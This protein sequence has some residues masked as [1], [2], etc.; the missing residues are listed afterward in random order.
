MT[1]RPLL[2]LALLLAGASA[3]HAAA[4]PAWNRADMDTTCAP[5]RNFYRYADGGWLD[6]SH[7]PAG[8]GSFGSFEE[9]ELRN[10]AALRALLEKASTSRS[11]K[12]STN[13]RLGD[14]YGAC[15]DSVAAEQAGLA[16]VRPHLDGI[17]SVRTP[18]TLAAE[19]GWLHANGIG[20]AFQLA[21]L[22]DPRR[23]TLTIAILGQGGLGL[24]DRDYYFREDTASLSLRAAYRRHVEKVFAMIGRPN[25]GDEARRVLALETRLAR[26]SMTNVE[27]RDPQ[28]TYHKV[29]LDTLRAWAPAV[30]WEAYFARRGMHVPDSLDVQQPGF[31]RALA[32]RFDDTPVA[33]WQAYLRWHVMQA[34]SPMLSK[35]YS[36]EAFAFD[37]RLT[38]AKE[39]LPRWERCVQ[40]ADTDL[41]DLLGA[42][43]VKEHFS[44][45]ARERA[46][47]MVK[48]M[49]AALG[50]RI[51]AVTWMSDT[52][53][54]AAK[55]KLDA[56]SEK[57]GYPDHARDYAGV[58]I[59]RGS[60]WSNHEASVRWDGER[61]IRKIGGPVDKHEWAMTAPT[62]NA[63][64][65]GSFNSINFPAGILQ[66]PFYDPSWDDALNYGAIG[67]VIG[68]EMTHGFDDR[69]RQFDADG[70]LRDW[71]TAAD[72]IRYKE[73]AGR[74]AAQFDGYAAIDTVHVNGRLTL[75]ENIADLGGLAVAYAAFEKAIAGKPH[76]SIDGFTPEQRFF[77]SW[78]RIWRTLE[79]PED[80]R[81]AVATDPHAP[82]E[83]RVNGPFSN[84]EE[85]AKAFGCKPGDAMVRNAEAR[86]RIW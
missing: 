53:R 40:G 11:S 34:A 14:Y 31:F 51:E 71:W 21:A 45:Q 69:G 54:K 61:R 82:S 84:L 29:P 42:A 26:A 36:D 13:Q 86:A 2:L 81:H 4:P 23:S 50:E 5:C 41:G 20:G 22:P 83:W 67:A 64:Y 68:H 49:E 76:P 80:L 57:I 47:G 3:A 77:L 56:F 66:P 1:R 72:A 35:A 55:L 70:N 17:D 15:M 75:G 65:S 46:L 79:T 58:V 6:H 16:P 24:P 48:R 10:E 63:Y 52:T 43:Y 73:R 18:A 12:G 27:R 33:D 30:P 78:A 62:V 28:A 74:V 44:S 32:E 60:W 8:F 7:L 38:G 85:F 59:S 37:R 19:L 25:P 39:Q 9:L